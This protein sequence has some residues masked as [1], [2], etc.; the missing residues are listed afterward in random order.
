MIYTNEGN[1][2]LRQTVNEPRVFGVRLSYRFGKQASTTKNDA[3]RDRERHAIRL[4]LVT[5]GQDHA[6]SR[7]FGQRT[8]TLRKP[9]DSPECHTVSPVMRQP[10]P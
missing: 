10:K 8:M 9:I 1:F 4:R 2:D 3:R 6:R 5:V 7:R